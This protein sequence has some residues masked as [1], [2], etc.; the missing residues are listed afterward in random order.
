MP[1]RR[2]APVALRTVDASDTRRGR[3]I[4]RCPGRP[5]RMGVLIPLIAKYRLTW[6]GSVVEP[7]TVIDALN[8]NE[9]RHPFE[10]QRA[11][12]LSFLCPK[13]RVALHTNPATTKSAFPR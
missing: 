1:C 4:N 13:K 7:G 10:L 12:V 5:E 6:R 11:R 9:A 2:K 8:P 3:P